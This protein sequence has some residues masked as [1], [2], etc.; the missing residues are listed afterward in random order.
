[1]NEGLS[2]IKYA[3]HLHAFAG[4]LLMCVHT[5]THEPYISTLFVVSY[6]CTGCIILGIHTVIGYGS[7]VYTCSYPN[8]K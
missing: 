2:L 7:D 8:V 3:M 5:F 6:K 4:Y 1:M